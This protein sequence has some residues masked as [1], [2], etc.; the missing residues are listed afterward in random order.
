MQLEIKT[1]LM[2]GELQIKNL[3]YGTEKEMVAGKI[4]EAK[5]ALKVQLI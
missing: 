5:R 4:T 2:V 3:L 1:R